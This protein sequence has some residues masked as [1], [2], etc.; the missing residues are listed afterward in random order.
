ML[1]CSLKE[2]LVQE[3]EWKPYT[4]IGVD[5]LIR[6]VLEGREGNIEG[7]FWSNFFSKCGKGFL[8]YFCTGNKNVAKVVDDVCSDLC[9]LDTVV[10]AVDK[11]TRESYLAGLNILLDEKDTKDFFLLTLESRSFEEIFLSYFGLHKFI[12]IGNK[13]LVEVFSGVQELLRDRVRLDSRMSGYEKYLSEYG[14]K[15]DIK[16]EERFVSWLLAQV[17]HE[18]RDIRI[19]KRRL[20]SCWLIG[21]CEAEENIRRACPQGEGLSCSFLEKFK[22]IEMNSV[23]A[24]GGVSLLDI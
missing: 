9:E 20:G 23:L 13:G 7:L 8:L 11:Y 24:I 1:S 17:T 15:A 4:Y 5:H 6:C 22:D 21:C 19:D 18:P 14:L 2:D 12:R 16:T 10:Y 3:L